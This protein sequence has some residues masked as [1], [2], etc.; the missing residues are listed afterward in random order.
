MPLRR[1]DGKGDG[2]L[3][4]TVQG[5]LDTDGTEPVDW[6]L[7]DRGLGTFKVWQ[8]PTLH[9]RKRDFLDKRRVF[10][11]WETTSGGRMSCPSPAS[12]AYGQ[13]GTERFLRGGKTI[14]QSHFGRLW[15]D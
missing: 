12:T 4:N 14:Q 15:K 9:V 7:I 8:V 5:A 10:K 2:L 3:G 1:L 6:P 11:F 13:T